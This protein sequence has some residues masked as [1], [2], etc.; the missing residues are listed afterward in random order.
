MLLLKTFELSERNRHDH[1]GDNIQRHPL[2]IFFAA[3]LIRDCFGVT[4]GTDLPE[5][6]Q[7][8]TLGS[9]PPSGRTGLSAYLTTE[10]PCAR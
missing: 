2:E 6:P 5:R 4:A 10:E 7:R 9:I 3:D 8:V 1:G